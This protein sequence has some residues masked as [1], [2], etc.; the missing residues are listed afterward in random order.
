MTDSH[1]VTRH[2]V[3]I[4]VSDTGSPG[5]APMDFLHPLGER[6]S[7]WDGV[8]LD[9]FAPAHRTITLDLR[10]HGTSDWPGTYSCSLMT[11]DVE[12]V[13]D[14]LGVGAV[15]LVGHS[16]GGAVAFELA[17]RR[18]DLVRAL[19]VE[20]VAPSH[21]QPARPVPTRP[22][23]DLPFDWDV[24]VAIRAEVDAGD[25]QL[26]EAIA[27]IQTPTLIVAGGPS[28]N[29]DQHH[30]AEAASR[31]GDGTIRTVEAGHYVHRERPDEFCDVVTA[32]LADIDTSH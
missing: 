18:P 27:G 2:S 19:I 32:W 31:V 6:G 3:R 5:A 10:G 26:W 13:L 21:G 11:D 20:D 24:V 4:A 29:V 1:P 16:L 28:S 30:L 17:A 9:R 8:V 22:D 7:D 15:F 23:V 14:Q 25:P 12:D